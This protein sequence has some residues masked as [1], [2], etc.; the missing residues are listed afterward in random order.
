MN[1]FSLF[2]FLLLWNILKQVSNVTDLTKRP[3]KLVH[4]CEEVTFNIL[5]D[6]KND[7]VD[8]FL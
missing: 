3:E 4:S 2:S 5:F 6:R 1:Y 8:L 7:T